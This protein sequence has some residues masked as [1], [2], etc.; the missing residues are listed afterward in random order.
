M[1][2]TRRGLGRQPAQF[3][4]HRHAVKREIAAEV[5][6]DQHAQGE[7]AMFGRELARTRADSA[8]PA[9]GDGA[10]SRAH[11]AFVHG[12]AACAF[13]ARTTWAALT[14]IPRMSL[15]Q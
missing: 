3:A 10:G 15:S 9:Q 4:P 7:S 13:E 6:L 11:R 12:S 5:R 1:A 14:C 8:L 2:R